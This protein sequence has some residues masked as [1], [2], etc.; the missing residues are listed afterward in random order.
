MAAVPFANP[1]PSVGRRSRR[2]CPSP[3]LGAEVGPLRE[4]ADRPAE[5]QAV[6]RVERVPVDET[7]QPLWLEERRLDETAAALGRGH[8]VLEP[9]PAGHLHLRPQAEQARPADLLHPPEV[10]RVADPEMVGVAAAEAHPDAADQAIHE[11]PD[12]PEDVRVRPARIAAET[13]H[14]GEH[15]LRRRGDDPPPTLDDHPLAGGDRRE[16]RPIRPGERVEPGG[17][18]VVA[19][20]LDRSPARAPRRREAGGG[21]TRRPARDRGRRPR[22]EGPR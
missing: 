4:D 3:T 22:C 15:P 12:P 20:D 1:A 19:V 2:T 17:L 10:E 13:L 11:A 14:L 5:D 18:D 16:A 6:H 7:R 8:L 9:R 21:R